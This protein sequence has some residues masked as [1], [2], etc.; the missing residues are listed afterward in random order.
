MSSN[1]TKKQQSKLRNC[2][3]LDYD[4]LNFLDLLDHKDLQDFYG[5]SGSLELPDLL[6]FRIFQGPSGSENKSE[7]FSRPSGEISGTLRTF[8]TF[9]VCQGPSRNI[10]R[11]FL[12]PSG[13]PRLSSFPDM[14]CFPT[15][16]D[17]SMLFQLPQS[18]QCSEGRIKKA[19][20]F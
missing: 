1:L 18:P 14:P 8:L 20:I 2:N 19:S 6:T 13:P 3:G 16:Q 7:T 4:L 11:T 9:Q 15:F 10:S 5:P 17:F 12:G